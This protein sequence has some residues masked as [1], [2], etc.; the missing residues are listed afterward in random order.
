MAEAPQRRASFVRRGDSDGPFS[1]SLRLGRLRVG[2][3]NRKRRPRELPASTGPCAAALPVIG[4]CVLGQ[5]PRNGARSCSGGRHR[6]AGGGR[7]RRGF[8]EA[9]G[10]D[11]RPGASQLAAAARPQAGTD[12]QARR[13]WCSLA[14]PSRNGNQTKAPVSTN[15]RSAVQPPLAA[16]LG[17]ALSRDLEP[18]VDR[19]RPERRL[20]LTVRA[21]RGIAKPPLLGR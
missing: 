19:L 13:G 17:R 18:T 21:R 8:R 4:V 9:A 16:R 3:W 5:I 6:R 20:R 14:R 10:H 1:G 2:R 15:Q 7:G 11:R 12:T